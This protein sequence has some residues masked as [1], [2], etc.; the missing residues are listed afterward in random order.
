VGIV[1]TGKISEN[2]LKRSILK[3]IPKE[4]EEIQKGA[5]VGADCALFS[6]CDCAHTQVLS[7]PV[8][9]ELLIRHAIL[10]AVNSLAAEGGRPKF[11]LLNLTLPEKA[12][13]IRLQEMMQAA[14]AFCSGLGIGIA[15]GHTEI[16]DAVTRTVVSVTAL[17]QRLHWETQGVKE[18]Q[19][20]IQQ[21]GEPANHIETAAQSQQDT[22]R[23]KENCGERQEKQLAGCDIVVTKYIGM[24]AAALLAHVKEQEL[25]QRFP[26]VMTEEAKGY[27]KYLSI[28][29]EAATAMK[30]GICRMHDIREGG[31][32]GALWEM[33]ERAGAG[34]SIDLKKIPMKQTVVEIC[35]YYDLNPYE[36]L[37]SG[38]LLIAAEDGE[39][40]I[41]A[42][43]REGIPAAVIGKFTDSNDR[44]I[45]NG[46]ET[47]YLDLP[48][49]DQ[50]RKLLHV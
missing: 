37:S 41:S 4:Q 43:A 46:E 1:K 7:L 40:L 49:P 24:E 39:T 26:S 28:L 12:R 14:Q 15:G 47:R 31:I 36:I 9:G 10:A 35:N 23:R 8:A 6:C 25:K 19:K 2:I 11:V 16:S 17:G 21:A 27:E 29:P 5:G 30:S 45:Q 18:R 13:E 42:L 20:E 44:I 38:C 34:L 33:A 48:K 32:F 22:D 50:I 3:Y